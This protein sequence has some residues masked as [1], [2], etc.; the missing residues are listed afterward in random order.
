M[1]TMPS[2]HPELLERVKRALKKSRSKWRHADNA[3]WQEFEARYREVL[4]RFGGRRGL[5]RE[6]CEDLAQEVLNEVRR[7]L[8]EFV[9]DRSRGPFGGWLMKIARSKCADMFRHWQKSPPTQQPSSSMA[10]GAIVDENAPEPHEAAIAHEQL[11]LF[12]QALREL[13]KEVRE[14]DVTL[15]IET[16]LKRRK[17]S[18][19]ARE[20]GISD[21][22]ARKVVE[23]SKKR[24][25]KIARRR[26]LK[27]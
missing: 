5:S 12:M 23:R 26:G 14:S 2:T 3:A 6:D 19:V 13:A 1:A 18:E 7:H 16:Q 27:W 17:T 9:Y 15:F 4:L 10:D 24:L 22:T 21:A 20:L 8:P 25:I 11:E